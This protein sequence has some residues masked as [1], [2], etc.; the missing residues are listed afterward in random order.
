MI[1]PRN[2]LDGGIYRSWLRK[3]IYNR[4]GLDIVRHW[5]HDGGL[6][7]MLAL[8]RRAEQNDFVQRQM[9]APQLI[10]VVTDINV[11]EKEGSKPLKLVGVD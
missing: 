1:P 8:D 11:A 4:N 2:P 5:N 6:H 10:P 7:T 9:T 3:H